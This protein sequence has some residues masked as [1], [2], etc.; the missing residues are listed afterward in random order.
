[1]TVSLKDLLHAQSIFEDQERI[2]AVAA[3][4]FQEAVQV[5]AD[6]LEEFALAGGKLENLDISKKIRES[7]QRVIDGRLA[8]HE[9]RLKYREAELDRA[10][11][12]GRLREAIKD[13]LPISKQIQPMGKREI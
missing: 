5:R 6:M 11:S 7:W 2:Y 1:M 12:E 13:V 10:A 4:V 9:Q 3:T 8:A